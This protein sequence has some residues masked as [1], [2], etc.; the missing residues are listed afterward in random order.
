MVHAAKNALAA[1][2][3]AVLRSQRHPQPAVVLASGTLDGK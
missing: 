3:I 2:N 1:L